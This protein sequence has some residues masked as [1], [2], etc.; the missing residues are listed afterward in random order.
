MTRGSRWTGEM[1]CVYAHHTSSALP[2]M[3]AVETELV[4]LVHQIRAS[5]LGAAKA[6]TSSIS[7]APSRR[8]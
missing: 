5:R 8:M 4:E 1:N 7:Y 2:S 3:N 6:T